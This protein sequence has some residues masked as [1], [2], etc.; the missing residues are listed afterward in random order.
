MRLLVMK[1]S[2]EMVAGHDL[3]WLSGAPHTNRRVIL[4]PDAATL[5]F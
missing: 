5:C 4:L 1:P 2:T 3:R